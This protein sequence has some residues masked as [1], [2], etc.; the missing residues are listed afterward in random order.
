MRETS[1][2]LRTI[3]DNTRVQQMMSCT[4]NFQVCLLVHQ[5]LAK[6]VFIMFGTGKIK[7][8]DFIRTLVLVKQQVTQRTNHMRNVNI[9]SQNLASMFSF[10]L[11]RCVSEK[12]LLEHED[13]L[14]SL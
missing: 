1:L 11:F 14:V 9:H 7:R 4:V 8:K 12:T 13:C 10:H 6:L 2:V 5:T 3:M